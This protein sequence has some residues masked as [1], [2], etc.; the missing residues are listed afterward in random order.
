MREC[1]VIK[2]M[3]IDEKSISFPVFVSV[4][5]ILVMMPSKDHTVVML[6]TGQSYK[7][8]DT[9]ESITNITKKYGVLKELV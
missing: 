6:T 8:L 7:V 2:L 5:N 3:A 9:V 4:H 1:F